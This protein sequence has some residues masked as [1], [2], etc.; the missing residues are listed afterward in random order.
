MKFREYIN[1]IRKMNLKNISN[2]NAPAKE[3]FETPLMSILYNIFGVSVKMVKLNKRKK[4]FVIYMHDG[5]DFVSKENLKAIKLLGFTKVYKETKKNT[6][7][8]YAEFLEDVD[9]EY[10]NIKNYTN[11]EIKKLGFHNK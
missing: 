2:V 1:E 6:D 3:L 11:A 4:Y 7:I 9:D 5:I 10:F 8:I